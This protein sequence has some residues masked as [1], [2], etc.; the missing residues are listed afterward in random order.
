MTRAELIRLLRTVRRALLMIVRH[1]EKEW[2][3]VL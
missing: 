2:P 3:E 1:I